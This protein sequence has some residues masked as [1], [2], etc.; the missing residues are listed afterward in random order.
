MALILP[1]ALWASGRSGASPPRDL[2]PNSFF[3]RGNSTRL[4]HGDREWRRL[5]YRK[6][7][8]T[9]IEDPRPPPPEYAYWY[10]LKEKEAMERGLPDPWYV[11][12]RRRNGERV[13]QPGTP[14]GEAW[15][16]SGIPYP[17][18][19]APREIRRA[20]SSGAQSARLSPDAGFR[21]DDPSYHYESWDPRSD[22][23]RITRDTA[24]LPGQDPCGQQAP[25]TTMDEIF[26]ECDLRGEPVRRQPR[27]R[28]T[29]PDPEAMRA[30]GERLFRRRP[31]ECVLSCGGCHHGPDALQGAFPRYPTYEPVLHRVIGLEERINLCRTR[32]QERPPLE[33]RSDQMMALL[34]YLRELE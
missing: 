32:H 8:P 10:W 2:E 5:E 34:V 3:S 29:D 15:R 24:P 28:L 23:S 17:E 14:L 31:N 1:L 30:R 33:A 9:V 21:G 16:P 6:G 13:P 20:R 18:R 12:G 25:W 26:P 19:G 4:T 27:P 22:V 11:Q 7:Q